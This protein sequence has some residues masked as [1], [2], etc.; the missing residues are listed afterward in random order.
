MVITFA[1]FLAGYLTHF[2]RAHLNLALGVHVARGVY[3]V[4]PLDARKDHEL[5]VIGAPCNLEQ[6]VEAVHAVLKYVWSFL[7]QICLTK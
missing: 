1:N 4:S 2:V 7:L 6:W 3:V 5:M